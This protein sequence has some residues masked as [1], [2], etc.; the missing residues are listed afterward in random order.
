MEFDPPVLFTEFSANIEAIVER[1]GNIGVYIP[2]Q[3]PLFCYFTET[4]DFY[5]CLN[6]TE[7]SAAVVL[8]SDGNAYTSSSQTPRVDRWNLDGTTESQVQPSAIVGSLYVDGTNLLA[9]A[10]SPGQ[11]VTRTPVALMGPIE[12]LLTP[13]AG[14]A[15]RA[16]AADLLYY[17][18]AFEPVNVGAPGGMQVYSRS[19]QAPLS[20]FMLPDVKAMATRA[21]N[22]QTDVF[23]RSVSSESEATTFRVLGG[24][25]PIQVCDSAF[26]S[27]DRVRGLAVDADAAYMMVNG[28]GVS[29]N[30][31]RFS[32]AGGECQPIASGIGTPGPIAAGQDAVFYADGPKL[33]RVLK[34]N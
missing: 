2:E 29:F 25:P 9:V 7:P 8:D 3:S 17:Y 30:L 31:H 21:D 19:S 16:L 6:F 1:N 10:P 5:A 4:A 32:D 14:V 23:L 22:I 11:A 26:G 20:L 24:D 18:V 15:P 33:Y 34:Q 27:V 13:P 28:P 12:P